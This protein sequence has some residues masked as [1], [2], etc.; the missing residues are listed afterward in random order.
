M[1]RRI[2]AAKCVWRVILLIITELIPSL[3]K[4]RRKKP[5]VFSDVNR[6]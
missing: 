6:D 1:V 2:T 5:R 4:K 3:P